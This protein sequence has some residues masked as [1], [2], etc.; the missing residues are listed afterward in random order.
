M[1]KDTLRRSAESALV[2]LWLPRPLPR[3]LYY[4]SIHPEGVL[5]HRPSA[6]RDQLMWLRENGYR[7]F[8]LAEAGALLREGRL[9]KKAVVITFDDGYEDN[10]TVALPILAREGI[11]ATFFVVSGLVG[12]SP[13]RSREGHKLYAGLRMMDRGQLRE[14]A[15]AGMEVGSHTRSHVHVRYTLER[16]RDEALKELSGSRED[17]EQIIGKTVESFAYPNG[18]KG[19]F[20]TATGEILAAAGYRYAVTTMWGGLT[21]SSDPLQLPRVEVRH[22]DTLETF[23]RKMEGR[24]DFMAPYCRLVNRSNRW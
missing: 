9:P 16:S 24:Y 21:P 12:D 13:R 20:S 1:I 10:A 4:H 5:S 18:Q 11:H 17:L 8:T 22:T 2:A 7:P 3:I 15:E 6:F 23:A 14:L 19:A